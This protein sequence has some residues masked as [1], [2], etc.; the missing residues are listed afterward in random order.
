MKKNALV[1]VEAQNCSNNI[2][3][4]IYCSCKPL[5]SLI[6]LN[7]RR[8]TLPFR[9]DFVTFADCSMIEDTWAVEGVIRT[10]GFPYQ[11]MKNALCSQD[12]YALPNTTIR[13]VVDMMDIEYAGDCEYDKLMVS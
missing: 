6:I 11:Y 4:G 3:A 8:E 13:V 9:F 5:N 7:C 10:P 2:D 12:I 1:V